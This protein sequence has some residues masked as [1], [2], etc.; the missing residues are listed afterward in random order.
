M[1]ATNNTP[2]TRRDDFTQDFGS[3]NGKI[4]SIRTELNL[5]KAAELTSNPSNYINLWDFNGSESQHWVFY[6]D[7]TL[8]AYQI[9]SIS[10]A[11]AMKS[12]TDGS[13]TMVTSRGNSRSRDYSTF[14]QLLKINNTNYYLIKNMA[15][16]LL[17]DLDNANTTN[18]T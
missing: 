15:S 11:Q 4:M 6:Y 7:G 10:T 17:L 14:W 5:N 16:G 8:S 13:M 18:G 9:I 12:N 3:L 1:A 2:D